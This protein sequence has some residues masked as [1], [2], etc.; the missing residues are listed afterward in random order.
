MLL[1][2][3]TMTG[4]AMFAIGMMVLAALAFV[5]IFVFGG[6]ATNSASAA[7]VK[8]NLICREMLRSEKTDYFISLMAEIFASK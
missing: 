3:L 8:E 4:A 6:G 5:A 7:T 1:T 2:K